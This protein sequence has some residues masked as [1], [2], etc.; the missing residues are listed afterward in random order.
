MLAHYLSILKT[1]DGEF[2]AL[3]QLEDADKDHLA[4]FFELSKI[5]KSTERFAS[6]PDITR[7]YID[8]VSQQIAEVWQ[9]RTAFVDATRWPADA[10]IKTGEH[11]VTYCCQR[12]EALGV[13]VIPV[14]GY[15]R[16]E[17][18]AYREA[19]Q[20][21]ELNRG[22]VCLRL[23]THAIEDSAESDHF[24]D[25]INQILEDMQITPKNCFVL[26]D[27]EDVTAVSI[28][29]L[30]EQGQRVM[31]VLLSMGFKFIGTAGCSIPSSI[32]KAVS[33]NDTTDK[34]IRKEWTLWRTLRAAY[35]QVSMFGDYGVRNPLSV[36]DRETP[37][38][39][40]KIRYTTTD[41]Y[42]IARGH[43]LRRG[44]KGDQMFDLADMI[45]NS[46]VFM[47]DDF[48]WGDHQ[49]VIRRDEREHPGNSTTWI[50][51]DTNHHITWVL[52]EVHEY[53]RRLTKIK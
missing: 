33:K 48:S 50:G 53:I 22:L 9:G 47:G 42:L 14:L 10:T 16:W 11:V 18:M 21:L 25:Q 44:N 12:L 40:G 24:K 6:R 27:F 19:L 35:P 51:I 41:S 8:E 49:L 45:M 46:P 17:S 36:D 26:I 39:N 29:D 4:V 32:D 13:G 38:T 5:G 43:S 34:V 7:A 20:S 2:T 23:D 31:G 37:D 52:A 1:R 3:A 15:D 30:V 28:A